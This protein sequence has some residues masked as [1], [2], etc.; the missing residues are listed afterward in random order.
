MIGPYERRAFLQ[1]IVALGHHLRIGAQAQH[2]A[3]VQLD[4]DPRGR[5]GAQPRRFRQRQVAFRRHPGVGGLEL[6]VDLA[7]EFAQPRIAGLAGEQGG[8]NE[9]KS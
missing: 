6:N 3:L 2:A 4:F 1:P 7:L 9:Q 5:A 8:G